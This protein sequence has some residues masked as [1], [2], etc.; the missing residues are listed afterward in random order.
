[1]LLTRLV[2]NIREGEP[3]F[4]DGG[5]GMRFN[6]VHVSD[7][8]RAVAAAMDL[9]HS[10]VVNVAGPEVLSLGDAVEELSAQLGVRA[11][12]RPR[13]DVRPTDLVADISRMKGLLVPPRVTFA[14]GATELCA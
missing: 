7:A 1:M 13:P 8:A 2:R 9:Q 14:E 6:P 12:I 10:A 3:I 11:E 4:L 5:E